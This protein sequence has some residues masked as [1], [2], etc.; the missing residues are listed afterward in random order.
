MT[1]LQLI[2]LGISA[3][4]AYKVFEHIQTLQS[5]DGNQNSNSN[6]NSDL[7]SNNED[8]GM[9]SFSP[10]SASELIQKAD[11]A[12][13]EGDAQKSL[14]FLIEAD[15]KA[16]NDTE[17]LF[18]LGYISASIDDN[19][20]AIRYY[21]RSLDINNNDEFVHN[22]LASVYRKE[23]QFSSA[24]LHLNDSLAIN[25]ANPVTYYNYGNLMLDMENEEAAQ[26]MYQKAIKLNPDFQEAKEE[27]AKLEKE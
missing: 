7:D 22:S 12:F 10:F 5:R 3:F 11:E 25:D 15:V 4:F 26:E 14:A 21:R 20:N 6:Q 2:M 16:P 24:K 9:D 18:K 13:E 1:T 19:M 8:K 17:I 27:L 23:K